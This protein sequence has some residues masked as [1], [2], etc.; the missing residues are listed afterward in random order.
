MILPKEWDKKAKQSEESL[1]RAIENFY[2]N[3]NYWGD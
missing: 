3:S 2:S 1:S